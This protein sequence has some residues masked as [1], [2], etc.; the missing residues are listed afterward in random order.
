MRLERGVET[1]LFA[2][3]VGV[4]LA[5]VGLPPPGAA[6]LPA[7]AALPLAAAAGFLLFRALAGSWACLGRPRGA[8]WHGALRL[9]S[10]SARAGVEEVAWRGYV[11]ALLVPPVGRAGALALSSGLFALAHGDV[12][13]RR[14]LVHVATGGVFGGVYLAT[15]RLEAA[16][17]AHV[18]YNCSVVLAVANASRDGPGVRGPD[19]RAPAA[20]EARLA[21]RRP[22]APEPRAASACPAEA[23]AVEKHFGDRAA[24]AGVDLRLEGGEVLALLGPNGAGKTTLVSILLGRRRPARS[25]RCCRSRR[26]R[27]PCA[28]RSSSRSSPPITNAPP[29]PAR[30]S[31]AS[32][33]P[34]ARDGRPVR[35]RAASADASRWRSRS[36]AGRVPSSSTSR[37]RA[38]TSRR[39]APSGSSS[40]R[41]RRRA[42]R[43]CS[44]RTTSRRQ[45]R[46]PRAW[47]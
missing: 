14:K 41:T 5:T 26:S 8:T 13:G 31:N 37:R 20:A 3:L 40:A 9:L 44:P 27:R 16:V 7:V 38:S 47:R 43:C 21:R 35:C 36:S 42:A 30:S 18:A 15:G 34:H 24:L 12:R 32:T 39:A 19:A 1:L 23:A 17:L 25:G 46:S 4:G 2:A 29:P 28:S 45:R 6:G 10:V 33:S 22:T 11:L